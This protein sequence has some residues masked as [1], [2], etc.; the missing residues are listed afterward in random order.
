M[1]AR[2]ILTMQL[3]NIYTHR[4]IIKC[5]I[6]RLALIMHVGHFDSDSACCSLSLFSFVRSLVHS[7]STTDINNHCTQ[8]IHWRRK[9]LT[10]EIHSM[11]L[12]FSYFFPKKKLLPSKFSTHSLQIPSVN[13][14]NMM[15]CDLSWLK[16][17]NFE[18]DFKTE[19]TKIQI[20]FKRVMCV[21][22]KQRLHIHTAGAL[23]NDWKYRISHTINIAHW[24]R[25]PGIA[26]QQQQQ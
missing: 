26:S 7:I 17:R 3:I 12:V 20:T 14:Q 11:P 5:H 10:L 9:Y 13:V 15:W 1:R 23:V 24:E 16:N 18:W 2:A 19:S 6:I 22:A 8:T 21:C 4:T 25:E